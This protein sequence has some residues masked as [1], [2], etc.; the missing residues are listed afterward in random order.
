MIVVNAANK[1]DS[2]FE[3]DNNTISI[4]TRDEKVINYDAM[5]KEKCAYAILNKIADFVC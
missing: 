5:S 4:I 1:P 3:G 2:G